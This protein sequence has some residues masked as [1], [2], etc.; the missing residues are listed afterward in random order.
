MG[1]NA[2]T[3]ETSELVKPDHG[4]SLY[5]PVWSPDGR[6]LSFDEVLYMEGKGPFSYYDFAA[7]EYI[8]MEQSFG[9]YSWSPDGETLAFDNMTYVPNGEEY[10]QIRSRQD[11][12]VSDFSTNFDPGFALMPAFSPQGDRVAYFAQLIDPF[13]DSPLYTLFVQPFPQGEAVNL[14]EYDNVYFINWSPDGNHIAFHHGMY[15]NQVITDVNLKTGEKVEF[16]GM[17]PSL[18]LV[19]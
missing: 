15:G 18:S 11:G 5:A 1:Y 16:L 4:L 8:A 10:I 2:D 19:P 9:L 13:E 3:G 6:F 14:G 12:S 7:G 17:Q